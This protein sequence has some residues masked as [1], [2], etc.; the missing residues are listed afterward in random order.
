YVI[1]PAC[2]RQFK[3]VNSLNCHRRTDCGR[4]RNYKCTLCKYASTRSND[5]KR[6]VERRH[7]DIPPC[8]KCKKKFYKY[9]T[10][11]Y[12]VRYYCGTEYKCN[13][14]GCRKTYKRKHDLANHQL[15]YHVGNQYTLGILEKS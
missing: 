7:G 3:N 4:P 11:Q 8:F 15:K 5:L 6:H 13:V 1:C 10:F 2:S 14:G 9:S 12:H